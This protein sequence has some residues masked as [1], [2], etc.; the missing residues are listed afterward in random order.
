ML[1]RRVR[2]PIGQLQ[3][4]ER[5]LIVGG[6]LDGHIDGLLHMLGT[7]YRGCV[8]AFNSDLCNI[9]TLV[10][11]VLDGRPSS[12]ALCEQ[13]WPPEQ[14]PGKNPGICCTCLV[15][16][17]SDHV[18]MARLPHTPQHRQARLLWCRERVDWSVEWC[19][20]I[21]SDESRFCLYASDGRT[22]VRRRPDERRFPECIRPRLTGPTSGFMV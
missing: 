22:S 3:P 8:A 12:D 17:N 21:F 14:N 5:G 10:D 6:Q 15:A 4:Y 13:W 18:S 1:R 9:P 7:V 20:V 2:T 19:P 11:Q 16:K